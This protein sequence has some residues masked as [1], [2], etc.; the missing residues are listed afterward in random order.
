MEGIMTSVLKVLNVVSI[1]FQRFVLWQ[2]RIGNRN[3]TDDARRA[4]AARLLSLQ[5]GPPIGSH[6]RSPLKWSP[7][8]GPVD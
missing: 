1:P 6:P 5:A 7:D 8:L 4:Q 2:R 3:G